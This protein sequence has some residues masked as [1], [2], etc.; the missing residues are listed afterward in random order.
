MRLPLGYKL[1]SS[2]QD[3]ETPTLGQL[4]S[5]FSSSRRAAAVLVFRA[6]DG[7]G[8]RPLQSQHRDC[9][10]SADGERGTF[11]DKEDF[12]SAHGLSCHRQCGLG[13]VGPKA[14]HGSGPPP[15]ACV[16]RLLH[17]MCCPPTEQQETGTCP[18]SLSEEGTLLEGTVVRGKCLLEQTYL[19]SE[20]GSIT[21]YSMTSNNVLDL[22]D[23][24]SSSAKWG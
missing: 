11:F 2:R 1:S 9:L 20:P 23:P 15:D 16:C 17:A 4:P 3:P 19:D 18:E 14:Q 5:H 8:L 7:A 10:G 13:V 22:S 6:Q 21:C 24:V 12:V